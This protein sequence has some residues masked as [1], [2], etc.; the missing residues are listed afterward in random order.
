MLSLNCFSAYYRVRQALRNL[1][2]YTLTIIRLQ[3]LLFGLVL[4]NKFQISLLYNEKAC[5][6][7]FEGIDDFSFSHLCKIHAILDIF[8]E[9]QLK[10]I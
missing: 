9:Y 2:R 7:I 8:S 5:P 4:T 3:N 10:Y 1:Y 6:V